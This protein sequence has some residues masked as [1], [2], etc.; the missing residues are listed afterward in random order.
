MFEIFE[1]ISLRDEREQGLITGVAKRELLMEKLPPR[2]I[3][4]L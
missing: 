4:S 3:I 1:I 2:N